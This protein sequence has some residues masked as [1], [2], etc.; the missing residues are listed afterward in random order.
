[1]GKITYKEALEAYMKNKERTEHAKIM[2]KVYK[3][4]KQYVYHET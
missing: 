4:K 1:M 2:D 3:K